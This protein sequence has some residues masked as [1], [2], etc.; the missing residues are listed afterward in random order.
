M[1]QAAA[2]GIFKE[3]AQDRRERFPCAGGSSSRAHGL[4]R[5]LSRLTKL[6][7]VVRPSGLSQVSPADAIP[8]RYIRFPGSGR[9]PFRRGPGPRPGKAK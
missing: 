9:T 2:E 7:S 3:P 4:C 5:P 1:L 6:K 8:Y